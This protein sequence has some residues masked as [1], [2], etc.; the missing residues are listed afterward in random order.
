MRVPVW[1]RQRGNTWILE[2][3]WNQKKT[4]AY[5]LGTKI[6]TGCPLGNLRSLHFAWRACQD[7]EA[8]HVIVRARFRD[9][10]LREAVHYY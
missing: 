9:V 7:E 2:C 6:Q 1:A 3:K 5:S 10:S 8:Q 4:H